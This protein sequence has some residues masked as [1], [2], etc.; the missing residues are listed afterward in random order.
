MCNLGRANLPSAE[1][2]WED[3]DTP[4]GSHSNIHC[5]KQA[6]FT[7]SPAKYLQKVMD[8]SSLSIPHKHSKIHSSSS[9]GDPI[10]GRCIKWKTFCHEMVMETQTQ[11]GEDFR[12]AK[13]EMGITLRML[14]AA[15][16]QYGNNLSFMQM[17]TVKGKSFPCA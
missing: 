14:T 17:F 1:Y 13:H 11:M 10:S 9:R 5:S 7:N 15:E 3:P 6:P 2:P 12:K 4:G 16:K 8:S